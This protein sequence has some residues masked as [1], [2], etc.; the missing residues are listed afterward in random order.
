MA[1]QNTAAL[2]AL[3]TAASFCCTSNLMPIFLLFHEL[4]LPRCTGGPTV[5]LL[6]VLVLQVLLFYVTKVLLFYVLR[7]DC[8]PTNCQL[9]T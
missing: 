9:M 7:Y 2:L 3:E 5:M 1:R 4:E 6:L 8:P